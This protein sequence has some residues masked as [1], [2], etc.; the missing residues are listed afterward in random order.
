MVEVN[1]SKIRALVLVVVCGAI[2]GFFIYMSWLHPEHLKLR[3]GT[4]FP[5]FVVLSLKYF[6]V[7]MLALTFVEAFGLLIDGLF[8]RAHDKGIE[9]HSIFASVHY[10]WDQIESVHT[11][12]LKY[13]SIVCF[14]V[15]ADQVKRIWFGLIPAKEVRIPQMYISGSLTEFMTQIAQFQNSQALFKK[16]S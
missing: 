3:N 9:R 7:P 10:R 8:F 11:M 14:K 5:A 12:E 4:P 1:V 15:K 6:I 16:A 13:Q 2:A